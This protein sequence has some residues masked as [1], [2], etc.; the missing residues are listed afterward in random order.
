MTTTGLT[1]QQEILHVRVLRR[2]M[3]DISEIIMRELASRP[4]HRVVS[5]TMSPI[6]Q[7]NNEVLVIVV[8][9]YLTSAAG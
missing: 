4:L 7:Y 6:E 2:D 9:E 3:N 5:M 1:R 8:I